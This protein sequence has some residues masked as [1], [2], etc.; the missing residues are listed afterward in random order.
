[1][2]TLLNKKACKIWKDYIITNYT[3]VTP[4]AGHIHYNQKCHLNA[5]HYSKTEKLEV[6]MCYIIGQ[7]EDPILHY[8]NYCPKKKKY[9]ENTIGTWCDANEYYAVR[10]I[11]EEEM[12]D[13]DV[14]FNSAINSM[15]N[16]LPWHV[17]MLSDNRV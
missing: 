7:D 15:N 9:I 16:I 4:I 10:E 2:I 14:S 1:M 5:V 3:K 6:Y 13:I 12:W 11:T 17:R 8:V